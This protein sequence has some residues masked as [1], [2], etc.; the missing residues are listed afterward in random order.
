MRAAPARRHSPCP[1]ATEPARSTEPPV[2][3]ASIAVIGLPRQH[4]SEVIA[5]PGC[6]G[7]TMTSPDLGTACFNGEAVGI[8]RALTQE[9]M[10]RAPTSGHWGATPRCSSGSH[11]KQQRV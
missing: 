8:L 11:L 9:E 1:A 5:V 4:R 10:G 2:H 3:L 6:L 7:C